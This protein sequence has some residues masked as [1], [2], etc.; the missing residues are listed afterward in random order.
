MDE[1]DA[2]RPGE[3][4]FGVSAGIAKALDPPPIGSLRRRF[5]TGAA[6]DHI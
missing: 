1:P 4:G 5:A 3:A 6:L 2:V